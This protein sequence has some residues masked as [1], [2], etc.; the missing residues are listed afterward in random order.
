MVKESEYDEAVEVFKDTDVNITKRGKKHL[1]AVLGQIECQKEFLADLV[2]NWVCKID[3][4][5]S[6][7]S[8][9]PQYAYTPVVKTQSLD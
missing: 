9:E 5:S 6:I 2:E 3:V 8:H 4:L 1:G 7:A